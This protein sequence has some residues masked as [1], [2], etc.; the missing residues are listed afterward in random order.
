MS[1][2]TNDDRGPYASSRWTAL[3][4]PHLWKSASQEQPS[5]PDI[6][7]LFA[8]AV[9]SCPQKG[10]LLYFDRVIS[11]D[12]LDKMSDAF[13]AVL[14]DK[15]YASGDRLA[16]FLQNVPQFAIAALAAWKL[17]GIL[18]P[19]N[20]M[21]TGREVSV[22][23]TDSHPKALVA[24][25]TLY[26]DAV[27]DLAEKPETIFT[28]SANDYQS[29]NDLRVLASKDKIETGVADFSSTIKANEGRRVD[30][31][32]IKGQD[33]AM[34]V[35]TSGT[36]GV[37]KGSMNS[38]AG[39][40]VTADSIGRWMHVERGAPVLGMAPL[41][42]ITG[43]VA[44]IVLSFALKS[45]LVLSYRFH[46]NVMA[47]S[48]EEHGAEVTFCAITALMGMLNEAT[49]LPAQLRSLT[50]I[51]TGG[52]PMPPAVLDQFSAKFGHYIY[53]GYGMTETNGPVFIVPADKKAPI[54]EASGTLSV[55]I[56]TPHTGAWIS[57]DNGKPAPVGE[58]G[59]IIISGPSL[60]AG[61]WNKAEETA[62]T[63]KQT[64]LCS[65]DIG[66][67]D[68]TGWFYLVDR[69]KDMINAGGYK[70]WP[71]EVEDVIYTHP[72]V[73]E[74][75][76]VGVPDSYRGET[77]RAVVSLKSGQYLTSEELKEFCKQRMAAYKYPRIIDIIDDLPKT[78]SGK[79]LRRSLRDLKIAPDGSVVVQEALIHHAKP[80]ASRESNEGR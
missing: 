49:V 37:P 6:V 55:G 14:A 52:A 74:A 75:A 45:P 13:A 11:Y 72:S 38:H 56:P 46:P 12:E 80:V 40:V 73:R 54:D 69:K 33:I 28:T 19:V 1:I 53:H 48:I 62:S 68:E 21:N 20:P 35:Y 3:Y 27:V 4:E 7:S 30:R 79:I 51:I 41:F 44:G 36:T 15:G 71:R 8:D 23:L 59:E 22:I 18:V 50:K 63:M 17:G 58:A 31:A 77:V 2:N 10:A 32:P 47:D 57:D 61:Y 34:L 78:M 70:V 66:F 60:A 9:R 76:V 67:M 39:A 43:L 25:D 26:R 65:G 24:Q 16:V 64:G 29:R 42:H 5:F